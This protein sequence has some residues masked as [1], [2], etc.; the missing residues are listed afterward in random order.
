MA[1]NQVIPKRGVW[2]QWDWVWHVAAYTILGLYSAIKLGNT[3]PTSSLLLILGISALLAV[4]YIPF[5][6]TPLRR[7]QGNPRRGL[8]YFV[9]GFL[10]W[11]VLLT[12]D[13]NALML[14]GMFLP[15]IFTRFPIRWA[16]AV[17]ITLTLGVFLI[18]PAK[19]Y[20]ILRFTRAGK[21]PR[22]RAGN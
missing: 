9:L 11:G 16:I 3:S 1:E 14:T 7:W 13:V 2:E 5:I 20:I 19:I 6:I 15:L 8:P 12:L 18:V 17:V 22:F 10:L 4:W 21:S